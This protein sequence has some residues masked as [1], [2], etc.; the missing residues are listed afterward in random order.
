[1]AT[2]SNILA[3]RVPWTEEPGGLQTMGSQN[4]THDWSDLACMHGARAQNF[5]AFSKP[6]SLPK[7]PCV[8]HPGCFLNSPLWGFHKGFITEAWLIK[9]LTIGPQFNLQPLSPP[10]RLGKGLK[11]LASNHLAGSPGSQPLLRYPGALPH[12]TPSFTSLT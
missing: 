11:V 12:P 1:M 8:H 3:W 5:P 2:H 6:A 9:S 7:T 4:L 10:R